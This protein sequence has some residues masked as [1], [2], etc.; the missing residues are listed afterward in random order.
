MKMDVICLGSKWM[1][2]MRKKL[3]FKKV[4]KIFIF[5]LEFFWKE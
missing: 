3:K 5:G 2:N 1:L 4:N